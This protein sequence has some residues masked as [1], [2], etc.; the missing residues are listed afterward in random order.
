MPYKERIRRSGAIHK[1]QKHYRLQNWPDYNQALINRGDLTLWLCE[2]LHHNWYAQKSLTPKK[3][4]PLHYSDHAITL[5]LT[6]RL[7]FKQKL[8]Q[9]QGVV[10]SLF[11]LLGLQLDVPNYTR[12]SRRGTVPLITRQLEKMDESSHL[13]IDSTGIKVFGESEWLETK[14]GKQYKRK[15]WR[16]LHL[17]INS[18]GFIVSRIMTS[19]LTDDRSC[20][21]AHL[22]Q[23]DAT[24]IT[25]LIADAGYDGQNV[26]SQLESV[27][28]KPIIPPARGSPSLSEEPCSVRQKGI[29][30]ID[31][32]GLYA[33]QTKND[34]GR[35]AKVENTIYRYKEV[36]GRKL[37]A[38][39]WD[40]QDAELHLGCF[41][42]NIFT[43]LGMPESVKI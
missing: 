23:A 22:K 21:D 8:R 2:D 32:K 10:K 18:K 28:I 19:H 24:K 27:N 31:K 26:Y 15:V 39:L 42:L 1:R 5:M 14:Y 16:K 11:H 40:T 29:N 30:Y 41:I 17:G 34:Y 4:R 6:L 9:T 33:W 12:L 36:I 20:L 13:V 38:R 37:N 43:N 25:Q 3:G 7:I 35:R